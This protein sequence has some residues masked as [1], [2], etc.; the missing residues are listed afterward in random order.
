MRR[1]RNWI[2]GWFPGTSRM[3]PNQ[4]TNKQVK[5]KKAW[6]S[7]SCRKFWQFKIKRII[8]IGLWW[9]SIVSRSGP[10]LSDNPESRQG[11]ARD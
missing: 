7:G 11:L 2:L 9:S 6:I 3:V 8:G 4:K 5:D 10:S 1:Y